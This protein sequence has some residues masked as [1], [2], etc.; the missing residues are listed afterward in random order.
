MSA[1][2]TT[3]EVN[4]DQDT[5]A[6]AEETAGNVANF[7]KEESTQDVTN[8][9]NEEVAQLVKTETAETVLNFAEETIKAVK[10]QNNTSFE[11]GIFLFLFEILIIK[12][13]L[14]WGSSPAWQQPA[15]L[16]Q[17]TGH[18]Q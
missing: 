4:Q 17:H 18:F 16:R 6:I 3:K 9:D 10:K 12:H 7:V 1:G 8:I 14:V 15:E 11:V 2:S 5:T 13:L